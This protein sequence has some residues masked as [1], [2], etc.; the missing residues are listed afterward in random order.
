MTPRILHLAGDWIDIF[1]K[2]YCR[3]DSSQHTDL[4]L[5]SFRRIGIKLQSSVAK[6]LKKNP[7]GRES[8]STLTFWTC[9]VYQ[10]SR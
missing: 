9:L 3:V 8:L 10:K 7:S 2:T 4:E 5:F 1:H 6:M